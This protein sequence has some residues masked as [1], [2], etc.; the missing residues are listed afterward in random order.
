VVPRLLEDYRTLR[1]IDPRG[2][3]IDLQR[4]SSTSYNVGDEF[5]VKVF[6]GACPVAGE[7]SVYYLTLQ[8]YDGQ[9]GID[10]GADEK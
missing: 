5:Y 1:I 4:S 3:E 10:G 2:D 8:S 9:L 6:E 7:Y